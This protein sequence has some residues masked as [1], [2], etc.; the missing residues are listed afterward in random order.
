MRRLRAEVA[1]IKERFADE[2]KSWKEVGDD[3]KDLLL[4]LDMIGK[5][6]F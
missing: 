4:W 2:E 3:I 1:S 6:T 5:K